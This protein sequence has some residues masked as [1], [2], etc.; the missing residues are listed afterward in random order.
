MCDP[1]PRSVGG[2]MPAAD[3]ASRGPRRTAGKLK[4]RAQQGA[5]RT[6]RLSELIE[7]NELL[8]LFEDMHGEGVGVSCSRTKDGGTIAWGFLAGG[9]PIM[10]YTA[11][12]GQ[13]LALLD[14][15]G[16]PD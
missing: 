15:L 13:W 5:A 2:T 11:D 1:R 7:G 3:P 6:V 16:T 10:R 4:D 8:E 9:K 12:R 14:E